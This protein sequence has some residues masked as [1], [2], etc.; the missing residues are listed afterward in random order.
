M[1]LLALLVWAAVAS[2]QG[3]RVILP[4]PAPEGPQPAWLDNA[5]TRRFM[6]WQ[7]LDREWRSG[8]MGRFMWFPIVSSG[9]L[10]M[11]FA[12]PLVGVA[13]ARRRRALRAGWAR[14]EAEDAAMRAAA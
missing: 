8:L 10:P 6:E 14:L 4:A 11:I 3:P 1:A 5:V 9:G 12:V 13:A 7:E 2:A